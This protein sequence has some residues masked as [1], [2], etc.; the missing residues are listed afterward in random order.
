MKRVLF[1]IAISV[2]LSIIAVAFLI[3]SNYNPFRK[4]WN[5]YVM[6]NK[7]EYLSC[8]KMSTFTEIKKVLAEHQ[9]VIDQIKDLS[10]DVEVVIGDHRG[11][12]CGERGKIVFYY[13]GHATRVKI[14][15]LINAKTFYGIPYD[16]VNY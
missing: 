3:E 15:E 13:G 2:V 10:A 4:L 14:E 11:K 12:D 7:I 16:L 9:E 5:N 6:D 1:L 8:E